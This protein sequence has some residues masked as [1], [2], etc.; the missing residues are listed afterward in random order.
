M[1]SEYYEAIYR[2][3]NI[4][5]INQ[6]TNLE[7]LRNALFVAIVIIL[8]PLG[9]LIGAYNVYI[10]IYDGE[11]FIAFMDTFIYILA[12]SIVF[13]K[14]IPVKYRRL[15]FVIII[16]I[17]SA[18]LLVIVPV[19]SPGIIWLLG[20]SIMATGIVSYRYGYFTMLLNT[21]LFTVIAILNISGNYELL[22]YNIFTV[23]SNRQSFQH[24]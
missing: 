20:V 8:I 15:L 17:M 14:K 6:A 13:L 1:L 3:V 12:I 4:P 18:I 9:F 21:L 7:E 10:A 11:L 22:L 16:H 19:K 2:K 24:H 5:K 23:S